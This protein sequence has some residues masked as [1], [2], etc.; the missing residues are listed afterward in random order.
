MHVSCDKVRI[1]PVAY[2]VKGNGVSTG[3]L[4]VPQSAQFLVVSQE[5]VFEPVRRTRIFLVKTMAYAGV[6]CSAW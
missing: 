5:V 3:V 4:G 2:D 1:P 6:D